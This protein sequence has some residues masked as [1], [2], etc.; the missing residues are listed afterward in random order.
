MNYESK[1]LIALFKKT[2]MNNHHVMEKLS[3]P[4]QEY[5]TKLLSHYK[6]TANAEVIYGTIG[7]LL[8]LGISYTAVKNKE[9]ITLGLLSIPI[10][11]SG[12]AQLINGL[13]RKKSL[14]KIQ[15]TFN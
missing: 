1:D 2:Y 7:I 13:E 11:G 3:S 8:S 14:K 6:K 5:L 15:N 9:L 10:L 12:L 4:T